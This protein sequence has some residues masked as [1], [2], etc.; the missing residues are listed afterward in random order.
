MTRKKLTTLPREYGETFPRDL[1]SLF[2]G[3]YAKGA[4]NA[5]KTL[6]MSGAQ[7]QAMFLNDTRFCG[8]RKLDIDE[9]VVQAKKIWK[10]K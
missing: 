2:Y 7:I 4:E 8:A 9:I 10:G 6:G 1:V 3:L 5:A